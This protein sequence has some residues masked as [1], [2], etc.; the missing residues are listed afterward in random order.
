MILAPH[1]SNT[2]ALASNI[3]QDIGSSFLLWSMYVTII[4]LTLQA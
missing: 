3:P 4:I 1:S 2:N